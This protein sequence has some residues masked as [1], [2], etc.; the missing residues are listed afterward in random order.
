MKMKALTEKE[1]SEIAIKEEL[2]VRGTA[3][4]HTESVGGVLDISNSRR[5][6]CHKGCGSTVDS[7]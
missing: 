5:L 2:Q 6:G 1:V 4:E 3:G 7:D